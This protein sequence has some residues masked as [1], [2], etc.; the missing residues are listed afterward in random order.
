MPQTEEKILL[1]DIEKYFETRKQTVKIC[2]PLHTEDYVLQPMADVSPPKWHLG[3]TTWFFET[4]IL[5]RFMPGYQ[6]YHPQ[7]SFIFNSYYESIGE[8]VLR[9]N[10]GNLSRPTVEDVMAYRDYVDHNMSNLLN[11][12]QD[13][14]MSAFEKFLVIG[15]NHEQQHQELLVTD[16]KYILYN[17][18]LMPAYLSA[19]ERTQ[20]GFKKDLE[21]LSVPAGMKRQGFEGEGFAWD[22]EKPAHDIYSDDFKIANRLITNGEYLEFMNDGGYSKFNLWLGE[23]WDK[24]KAETWQAPLYWHQIDGEWMNYTLS[25]LKEVDPD[26]PVTH[27][28]FYEADAFASW[29]ESRLLTEPEWETSANYFKPN[30]K[31][32]NF[33]ESEILHPASLNNNSELCAQ[34]LGDTWEWTYSGYFPYPG[35]KREEGALGEYNGKFM[36]NQMI[37]RGGSCATPENHIR[38]TYRNF[39]HADKRWQFTGIRLAK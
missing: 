12:L 30:I 20:T 39:F 16:I 36:I 15:I 28:S 29:A 27:I 23:G 17:N 25:G 1:V 7:Y 9:V 14:D 22:N 3:H 26:E 35:Y 24:V 38:T 4:F 8:R 11:V 5:K 2:A 32:G 31:N 6:P 33:V 18:P 34:L 21:F 19:G 10:R 13:K 37:L